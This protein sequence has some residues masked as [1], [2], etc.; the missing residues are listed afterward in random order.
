MTPRM[1]K[2][3]RLRLGH[4]QAKFGRCLGV[5]RCTVNRWEGGLQTIPAKLPKF[6]D[7]PTRHQLLTLTDEELRKVTR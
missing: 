7:A 1:L 4:S 2:A 3:W 5:S 6:V